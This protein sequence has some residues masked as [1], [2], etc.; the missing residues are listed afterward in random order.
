MDAKDNRNQAGDQTKRLAASKVAPCDSDRD[1]IPTVPHKKKAR[2]G[3]LT[4]FKYQGKKPPSIKV[5]CITTCYA[6]ILKSLS[7]SIN[8]IAQRI[9]LDA[10]TTRNPP[11]KAWEEV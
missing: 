1:K 7:V 2:T 6:R 3:V 11:R 9:A 5:P 10:V 4:A 8:L